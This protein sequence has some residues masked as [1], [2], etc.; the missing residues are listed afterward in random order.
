MWVLRTWKLFELL[1]FKFSDGAAR[2]KKCFVINYFEGVN[3]NIDV[4]SPVFH[5]CD[6]LIL[7]NS[8]L[9]AVSK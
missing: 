4:P 9:N 5:P 3:L 8:V 7:R 6:T 1:F 2:T